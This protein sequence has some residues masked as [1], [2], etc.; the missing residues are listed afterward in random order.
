MV[1]QIGRDES[2]SRRSRTNYKYRVKEEKQTLVLAHYLETSNKT[3]KHNLQLLPNLV[4]AS[5]GAVG[6]C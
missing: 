5:M 4:E 3:S 1:I 2:P 6:I